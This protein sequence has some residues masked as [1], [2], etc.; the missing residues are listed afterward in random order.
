MCFIWSSHFTAIATQNNTNWLRYI[1]LIFLFHIRRTD[2][3]TCRLSLRRLRFDTVCVEFLSD[4]MAL[5]QV[6]LPPV[7]VPLSVALHN[8]PHSALPQWYIYQKDKR[9]KPGELHTKECSFVYRGSIRQNITCIFSVLHLSLWA[10][11]RVST[12]KWSDWLAGW[13]ARRPSNLSCF[14]WSD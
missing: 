14:Q 13:P 1:Y 10:P 6:F 11:K 4:K 5:R 7:W 9:A 3:A 2:A 12:P 8:A